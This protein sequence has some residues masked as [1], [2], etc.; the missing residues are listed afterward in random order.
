MSIWSTIGKVGG[1][2]AAPFT[3][4]ASLWGSLALGAGG[5]AAGYGLS[6]AFGGSKD[7]GNP[8]D[9]F[10]SLLT[11]Q[12]QGLQSQGTELA[13][14]GGQTIQPLIQYLQGIFG[15]NPSGVLDATK[16]QRGRVIDQYDA[17]RKALAEFG[18]R[19]GGTTSASANSYTSEA[20]ALNEITS[21][22]QSEA[23]GLTAQLGTQLTGLGLSAEQL[24]SQDLESVI[25]TI[26]GRESLDTE[27]R[28]QNLAALS[29]LGEAL[30]SIIGAK[31]LAG[32][33]K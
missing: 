19:G 3:G 21:D 20:N 11:K 26:L 7:D 15:S 27:K 17:A 28:G 6:K 30:G 10:T 2:A 5:A 22:A 14:Q 29:G 13:G 4:G 31:I 12:S 18:P 25:R 9:D 8:E 24:A 16:S 33:K 23:R 1:I 32:K